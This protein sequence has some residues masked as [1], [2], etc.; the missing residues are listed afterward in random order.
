[1]IVNINAHS[2]ILRTSKDT[3][4]VLNMYG[5]SIQVISFFYFILEAT[6]AA[7]LTAY[8][9][10]NVHGSDTCTLVYLAIKL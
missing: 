4:F 6:T 9:L 8:C 3:I 2:M 5:N 10:Y 7:E 1:M